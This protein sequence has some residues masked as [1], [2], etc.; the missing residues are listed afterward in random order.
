MVTNDVFLVD[1]V[2]D[3]TQDSDDLDIVVHVRRSSRARLSHAKWR[4]K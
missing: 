4:S 1:I 2:V 3:P